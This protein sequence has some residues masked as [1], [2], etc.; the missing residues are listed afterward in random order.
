MENF[1]VPPNFRTKSNILEILT[2]YPLLIGKVKKHF[3]LLFLK[4][5]ACLHGKKKENGW[6][7]CLPGIFE[8]LLPI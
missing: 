8:R 3:T 5:K 2:L 6:K 4:P 1:P 7:R